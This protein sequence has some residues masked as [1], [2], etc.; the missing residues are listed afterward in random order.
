MSKSAVHETMRLATFD[1]TFPKPWTG[2]EKLAAYM[3]KHVDYIRSV[4]SAE[5]LL[6]F[7]PLDGW[8][9][10]CQFLRK[11][12]LEEPLPCINKGRNTANVFWDH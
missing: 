8:E 6:E 5:N 12:F 1:Y 9:V 3:L 7:R 2:Q 10:L 11:I 4:V